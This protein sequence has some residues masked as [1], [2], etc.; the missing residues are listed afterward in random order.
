MNKRSLYPHLVA[1][2]AVC[3]LPVSAFAH[4]L[5]GPATGFAAGFVHPLSG[6]DHL[7]A[8][9]AVGLWAAQLGGR[10]LWVVPATF[11][12]VMLAG[13]ALGMYGAPVPFVEAGILT[14]VLVLG[15]LVATAMR[16]PVAAGALLVGVFALFHG[17][18]HGSEMPLSVAGM[19]YSA[20]FAAATALL[21]ASGMATGIAVQKLNMQKLARLAGGAIAVGGLYLAVA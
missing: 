10:A 9:V 11:V 7:L 17:H 13:A 20:G 14:S 19:A 21:H 8:M 6:I 5:A 18:A 16:L 3:L 12:A 2:G 1:L 4:P 15:V